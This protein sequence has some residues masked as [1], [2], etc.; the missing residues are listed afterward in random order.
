MKLVKHLSDIWTIRNFLEIETCKSLINEIE[1]SGFFHKK[2]KILH[3]D[4][5]FDLNNRIF[6]KSL[7]F[8]GLIWQ[9]IQKYTPKYNDDYYPIGVNEQFRL[10]KYFTGQVFE[11]HR[12]S[13][14]IRNE[15][16]RSFFSLLIYFNNDFEG[17]E[18]TFD[19]FSVKPESG[20]AVIFPHTLL[21][22]GAIVTKGCK[23]ILRSDI[24]FRRINRG[25]N[26]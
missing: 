2:F 18:T 9:K 24:M 1:E 6:F 13:P 7:E 23:Y 17:G 8:A 21:H 16:E 10:Y 15:N 12:D 3:K 25:S 20:M 11:K 14:F 5:E 26:S 4:N 22:S 19:V